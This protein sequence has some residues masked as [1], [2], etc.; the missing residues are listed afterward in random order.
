MLAVAALFSR[1]A[2]F[3]SDSNLAGTRE[4]KRYR[5]HVLP[6]IETSSYPHTGEPR[7][8]LFKLKLRTDNRR[9]WILFKKENSGARNMTRRILWR[10]SDE[11]LKSCINYELIFIRK[12]KRDLGENTGNKSEV[13]KICNY[14]MDLILFDFTFWLFSCRNRLKL[15]EQSKW[16]FY[17][18]LL[19]FANPTI[20]Y[21]HEPATFIE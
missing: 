17:Q 16:Y 6:V 11:I 21:L 19:H 4:R 10:V 3:R 15:L 12:Q 8:R 20:W 1:S 18:I 7:V 9:I 2:A 14:S 13:W 5:S